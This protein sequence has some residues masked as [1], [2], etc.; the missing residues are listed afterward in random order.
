MAK[1]GKYLRNHLGYDT[2]TNIYSDHILKK[3][4]GTKL[5]KVPTKSSRVRY[6][7]RYILKKVNRTKWGKV[8]TTLSC[9]RYIYYRSTHIGQ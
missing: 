6:E 7:C 3:A 9:V 4:S 5:R 8:P 1:I 2:Y